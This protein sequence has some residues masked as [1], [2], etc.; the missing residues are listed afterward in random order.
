MVCG[1]E[2]GSVPGGSEMVSVFGD[3]DGAWYCLTAVRCGFW[4]CEFGVDW[5]L[6]WVV[7]VCRCRVPVILYS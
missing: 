5:L 6:V 2:Y 3:C 7:L 4:R 1:C